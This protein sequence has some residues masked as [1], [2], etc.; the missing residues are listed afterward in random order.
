MRTETAQRDQ[1]QRDRIT[2]LVRRVKVAVGQNKWV[3]A[4]VWPYYQNKW[5]WKVSTGY[6]DYYQDSKGWLTA[7][8]ADAIAP[9]M[10]GSVADELDKW[11]ILLND[12]LSDSHGKPVY[13]GIN[14]DYDDFEAIARRIEAS[15]EAGPSG[16]AI[17]SYGALNT[18]NYLDKLAAG[19]YAK[20]ALLPANPAQ[21]TAV[22]G[23]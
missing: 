9:M 14:A 20:P 18:R 16:H 23:K 3:S 1:W 10:Y 15:R 19:P 6:D 22:I 12:F 11:Q 17:Y 7:G 8:Y 2:D 21:G 13:P 5:G 4:A